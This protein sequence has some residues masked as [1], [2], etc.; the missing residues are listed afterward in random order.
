MQNRRETNTSMAPSAR[1]SVQTSI[2]MPVPSQVAQVT[3]T[4][5]DDPYKGQIPSFSPTR[6][7]RYKPKDAFENEEK[8]GFADFGGDDPRT[9]ERKPLV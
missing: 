2:P 6:A 8:S 4:E 3:S 5:D 7:M 1:E 9:M